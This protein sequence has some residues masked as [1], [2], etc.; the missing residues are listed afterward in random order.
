M[1]EEGLDVPKC[2][3]VVRYDFPLTFQ[4]YVQS[5]GRARAKRNSRYRLLVEQGE[6][7]E[8][9]K[10]LEEYCA[11]ERELQEICHDREVPDEDAIER[12]M[13]HLVP[14]YRSSENDDSPE[15]TVDQSLSLM[16]RYVS[17]KVYCV[18]INVY[19]TYTFIH[20]PFCKW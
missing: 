10:K 16:Y 3:L 4:S 13:K 1:V 15:V 18:M 19:S 12:R 14:P 20:C 5:K 9:K 11:L 8:Y 7:T 6:Y 17:W 2:N